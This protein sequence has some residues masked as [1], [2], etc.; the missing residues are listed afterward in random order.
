MPG[1]P[2]KL[3]HSLPAP[4]TIPDAIEN[5]PLA[6]ALGYKQFVLL[7][8][9]LPPPT[10]YTTC[11]AARASLHAQNITHIPHM[12]RD[13]SP[14]ELSPLQRTA[15][16]VQAQAAL[17]P[18]Y[19]ESQPPSPARSST[20][21]SSSYRT[22]TSSDETSLKPSLARTSSMQQQPSTH[23]RAPSTTATHRPQYDSRSRR[24]SL[25][26]PQ[27]PPGSGYPMALDVAPPRRPEGE[28]RKASTSS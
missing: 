7:T 24:S 10:R 2:A 20:K 15:L 4:S 18:P 3:P 22:T 17:A 26:F 13:Q 1:A 27:S 9:S 23:K 25:P 28:D 21:T 16:W 8:P 6:I 14:P 19:A 5:H 11:P 12:P